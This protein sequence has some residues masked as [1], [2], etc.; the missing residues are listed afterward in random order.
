[1][2][3]IFFALLITLPFVGQAQDNSVK[4][5]LSPAMFLTNNFGVNYERKLSDAFSANIRLNL[6][7]KNALPFNGLATN[8]LGDVL[9][10]AGVNSDVLRTKIISYGA[11]LQFR[12]FP[13]KEALKG[14]Y[15]AP[16][17]GL[18]AGKMKPFTFDFPD[19]NDPTIKH[20]G[21]VNTSF[22]FFGAGLGIGNQWIMDNGL[23]LD[24]MWFGLGAGSNKIKIDGS[25]NSGGNVDYADINTDVTTFLADNAEDLD[26]FKV[27]VTSTYSASNI[28][29]IAKHTF[30]Y[31]KILNFSIGYS[32]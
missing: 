20:G 2:K 31:M 4:L 23:T 3:K 28:E 15:L 9:D 5:T 14:F 11:S 25:D 22:L 7:S 29:L 13:G 12:Y 17:F 21:E 8:L 24:I 32:F 16:Y 19:S 30:P 27:D 1:M 6:T 18:Q 26:K 10:S